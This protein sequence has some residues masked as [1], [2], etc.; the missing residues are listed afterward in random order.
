M[1]GFLE[2]LLSWLGRI[3]RKIFRTEVRPATQLSAQYLGKDGQ[4]ERYRFQWIPSPSTFVEKVALVHTSGGDPEVV[5]ADL[6]PSTV[7]TTAEFIT[8]AQIQAWIR[9]W[10]DNGTVAD[11]PRIDFIATNNEAVLPANGLTV[12]WEAHIP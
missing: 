3:F 7:E 2:R 12:N 8:D 5:G 11:S 6:P 1:R 10:G 9:T 4:M